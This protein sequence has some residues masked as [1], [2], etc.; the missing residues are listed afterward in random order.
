[1]IAVAPSRRRVFALALAPVVAAAC[2]SQENLDEL[3]KTGLSEGKV[4]YST[5]GTMQHRELENWSLLAF[6]KNYTDLKVD[7]VWSPTEAEHVAKQISLLSGGTPPDVMRL[8]AWSA[9]TFYNE[10]VAR[11]LDPY[12]RRDGF[13]TDHLAPP[14]DVATFKRGFFAL[15][16]GQ[17][18]TWVVFYNR[19]LLS[20]AGVKNPAPTWTWED[21]LQASR[22]LTRPSA[23]GGGQWGT[24][25]DPLADFYHPW[26]WGAGGDDIEPTREAAAIDQPAAVEALEWLADLRLKH[27][28]APPAGELAD[29]WQAFTSGRIAMWY[30]PADAELELTKLRAVDFAIAPQPRGKSGQHGGYRPDVMVMSFNAQHPDDGWELL[31]FLV[32]V[33]IQRLELEN[34]LW[35][36]QASAIVG[37]ESYRQLAVPPYD[38]RPGIPNALFRARTPVIL[39]RGDEMR[40]AIQRELAPFWQGSRG[41]KEATA[42]AAKAVNII[43]KGEA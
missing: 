34:A 24:A 32:D 6:E 11:R 8:P 5:W 1:M 23:A 38:R 14:F 26:L 21:F 27:R 13:K 37:E 42:A 4:I 16:R 15:P 10:E 18:G 35:L 33:E 31:Q 3:P 7:V 43:I 30:G 25:L 40:V 17:S 29:S 41:A 20:Q 19:Q 36:P 12:F 9:P 22:E 28:V 39:P 2:G